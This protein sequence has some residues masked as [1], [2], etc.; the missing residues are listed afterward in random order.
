MIDCII[1]GAKLK[2]TITGGEFFVRAGSTPDNLNF[3]KAEKIDFSTAEKLDEDV[4]LEV[5]VECSA[6][7]SHKVFAHID[8]VIRTDIYN[9]IATAAITLRNKYHTI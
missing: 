2:V 7:P 5:I 4:M 9:R 3:E 6:D 8:S 1:C